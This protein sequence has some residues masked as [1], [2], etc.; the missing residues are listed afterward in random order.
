MTLKFFAKVTALAGDGELGAQHAELS[1][2][3]P[4]D[5]LVDGLLVELAGNDRAL[6]RQ[7]F[8]IPDRHSGVLE[9]LRAEQRPD[10]P[11]GGL[12]NLFRDGWIGQ[13]RASK[14]SGDVS[15]TDAAAP[16][17]CNCLQCSLP[18]PGPDGF[19]E[20]SQPDT[21]LIGLGTT[22]NSSDNRIDALLSGWRIGSSGPAVVSFSFVNSLTA[23][24]YTGE[25]VSELSDT[26]KTSVRTILKSYIEPLVGLVFNEITESLGNYG[27]MRFMFSNMAGNGSY[28]YAYYPTSDQTSSKASDVHLSNAYIDPNYGSSNNFAAGPG[29]H[30]YTTLIHEIGHA[31]GLKHPFSGSPTLPSSEDNQINTVMTYNF[32]GRSPST[33]MPYDVAALRYIYGTKGFNTNDTIYSFS[34]THRFTSNG[35]GSTT[36]GTSTPQRI[37]LVDDGGTDT[38]DL[39]GLAPVSNGYRIDLRPG[40]IITTQDQYTPS[41]GF[42]QLGTSLGLDTLL[43]NVITSSSNDYF[44]ANTAANRFTGYGLSALTGQDV[45]EGANQLD[46]LDLSAFSEASV[47]Q[48][49]SGMDLVFGLGSGRSVT[50]KNY[51]GQ[52]VGSRLQVQFAAPSYT[53]VEAFGTTK[54]V[55]DGTH[56]LYAQVGSATPVGIKNGGTQIYQGIYSGWETLAA[57]TVAG[58]NQVLWK[59]TAGNYLHLWT[60]DSNWNRISSMGTWGLNSAEAFTQETNFQQDFNGDGLVGSPNIYNLTFNV[61]I[62]DPL[63]TYSAYHSPIRAAIQSAGRSWDSYIKGFNVDLD[64]VVNF[65]SSIPRATGG[66]VTS[67]FVRNNG[68][69]NIF[70]QGAAAEIKTGVDPNGTA[71][72]IEIEFNPDYLI[73][74]LWFDSDP[75]LRTAPVP[76]NRTDA[77]SVLMHELGHALAFNGWMNGITGT[78]PGNY[79]SSFDEKVNFLNGDFFFT[80]SQATAVYG[81]PV[82][83]TYGNPWHL[84][85]SSP[86]PGSDLIPDL[87]NGV[88][89]NRGTRYGISPLDVAI[90]A[91]TGLPV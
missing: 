55:K 46:I 43:E 18:S 75:L 31:L 79:Q 14:R 13:D 29:N 60:L 23:S 38:L 78:M 82:P 69:Y 37:T 71:P 89:F 56:N 40:G 42:S 7:A 8:Q 54:L 65:N 85:N 90:L 48:T 5:A 67:S 39:S 77:V 25:V 70:D 84:G 50:V 12:T 80:G 22:A 24:A 11:G 57:E 44:V 4:V 87:M 10:T 34:H 1:R 74:E 58:V 68:T 19:R 28:A 33:L 72:D 41:T 36:W 30:G 6:D 21:T 9:P 73:N 35:S 51:Y 45:I 27:Q 64:V 49:Q 17:R 62:D 81:S 83:V 3:T 59:N 26:I 53:T 47:S 63:N 16:I 32:G 20:L 2:L 91:D 15:G 66:S 52:S 86:R 88:V 76:S 61:V